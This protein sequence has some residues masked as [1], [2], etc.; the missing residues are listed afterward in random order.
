MS[1]SEVFAL[2]A[3][4]TQIFQ[5]SSS[6]VITYFHDNSLILSVRIIAVL[7]VIL[8]VQY[9]NNIEDFHMIMQIAVNE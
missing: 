2:A 8:M 9:G 5:F 4:M 7:T 3:A 1:S 6:I